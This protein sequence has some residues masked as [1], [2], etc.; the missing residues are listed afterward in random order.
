M[1]S[2]CSITSSSVMLSSKSSTSRNSRS[3]RP[4]S[5]LPNT[6]VH[7]AQCTFLSDESFRYLLATMSAPKNTRS[8]AHSSRAMWRWGLA[9][10]RYTRVAKTT[11][12]STS[13]RVR[14][15]LTMRVKAVPSECLDRERPRPECDG[16][17]RTKSTVSM[18]ESIRCST[19]GRE[20]FWSTS[21]RRAG[22]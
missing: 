6:P 13:A 1:A 15:L 16:R 4:M 21:S 5:R 2:W 14:T 18:T 3:I 8:L 20:S 11:G 9:L 7:T 19:M 17:L 22:E 10:L 12:T